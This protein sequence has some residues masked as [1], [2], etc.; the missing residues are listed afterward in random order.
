[1]TDF[2]RFIMCTF[3]GDDMMIMVVFSSIIRL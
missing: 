2:G 3:L 1:M